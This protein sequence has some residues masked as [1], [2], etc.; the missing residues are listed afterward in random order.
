M[1]P[2]LQR[3][4]GTSSTSTTTIRGTGKLVGPKGIGAEDIKNDKAHHPGGSLHAKCKPSMHL[5]WSCAIGRRT[6]TLA[7]ADTWFEREILPE[8][9][10]WPGG[11]SAY[12]YV[13]AGPRGIVKRANTPDPN[14]LCGDA[15]LWVKSRFL[16]YFDTFRTK[17][18]YRLGLIQWDGSVLNHAA[19]VMM[20][21][22][23]YQFQSYK[24]EWQFPDRKLSL[25]KGVE[26]YT[27]DELF[28]LR[29]YDL[30]F[31]KMTTVKDWWSNCDNM[32]G[33]IS[34]IGYIDGA[35]F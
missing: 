21:A 34:L 15:V 24:M 2:D 7:E 1:D 32:D 8:R 28:A 23:K 22:D 29:V 16:S 26:E 13:W 5:L 4:A 35:E 12:R 27:Q 31:K 33:V 18:G 25:V 17:D 19:C 9:T 14:G 20:K 10:A 6:P 3:K 30:Y 11:F